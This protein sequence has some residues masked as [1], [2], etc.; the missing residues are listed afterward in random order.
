MTDFGENY[1]ALPREKRP[2][3]WNARPSA[4]AAA[5]LFCIVVLVG[6]VAIRAVLAVSGAMA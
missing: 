4:G 1:P 3:D 5:F 6:V 2:I